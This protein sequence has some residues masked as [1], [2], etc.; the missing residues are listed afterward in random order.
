MRAPSH[1]LGWLSLLAVFGACTSGPPTLTELRNFSYPGIDGVQVT[2]T[3]GVFEGL[4]FVPGAASR[5]QVRLVENILAIG[6]L[7][8]DGVGEAVVILVSNSGGSGVYSYLDVVGRRLGRLRALGTVLLGDRIQIRSLSVRSGEIV[9][10][11]VVSGPNEGLC[12]PTA[13]QQ[14]TFK[15]E[16]GGVVQAAK[17]EQGALAIGDIEGRTW[18]LSSM[19]SNDSIPTDVEITAVFGD[20]RV[21][22]SSGCN[23]YSASLVSADPHSLEIGATAGTRMACPP[24][25][26]DVEQR[27][28][29][30]LGQSIQF[31]FRFG[32]LALTYS[33][34]QTDG[35]LLFVGTD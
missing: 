21:A 33:D 30:L 7:D 11:M 24:A 23:R 27:Y 20:G 8:G 26:M 31:G 29:F 34:G 17:E 2:L 19:S 15:L 10:E 1:H 18:R 12:C 25:V 32:D 28:L 9:V 3:D 35:V 14:V 6:D 13:K 22:G 5:Q 4:P 16:D